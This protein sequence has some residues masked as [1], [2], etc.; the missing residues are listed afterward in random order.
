MRRELGIIAFLKMVLN[1]QTFSFFSLQSFHLIK[2]FGFT[3]PSRIL[4]SIA[5]T[6]KRNE[7]FR[8]IDPCG[9]GPG[10]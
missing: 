7:N 9:Q 5:T 2:D 4:Y 3:I 10:N 8:R 6:N 1:K